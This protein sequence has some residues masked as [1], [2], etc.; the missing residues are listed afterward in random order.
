MIL[1]KILGYILIAAG[2]AAIIITCFYSYNIY[3]GKTSAPIIFQIP[4]SVETS[5]S[6][7]QGL[8]GQIEQTV[9]KQLSKILPPAVFSKILNLATWSLFAFI[10]IFAGGTI[11]NIGVKL[12]K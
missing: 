1:T 4:V 11:T 8:Q 7:S 10:L 5:S 2:L 12:V 9:Q 3:M 6:D